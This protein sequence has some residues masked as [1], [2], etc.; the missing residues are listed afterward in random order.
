MSTT[1]KSPRKVALVALA[2]AE[3]TLRPYSH[4]FSPRTFTQPQLFACLAIKTFFKTDYRGITA[5]LADMPD[6]CKAIGLVKVPHFTTLQ[7]AARRLMASAV[8]KKI[9]EGTIRQ[10]LG[11]QPRIELAAVDSTGMESHHISQYFVRR[12]ASETSPWQSMH[13]T[14][15]PKLAVV[16]D[17]KSHIILSTLRK[18]GPT[19]DINQLRQTLRPAVGR[20]KIE[21]LLA[22]AGYDSEPNHKF[23]REELGI[24]TIIPARHGRPGKHPPK[25]KYRRLMREEFDSERYGQRW[26]VETVF[27]MIK[28]NL[29]SALH[30][31]SYWSQCRELMLLAIT[32]NIMIVMPVELFYRAVLTPLFGSDRRGYHITALTGLTTKHPISDLSPAGGG[33]SVGPW[34]TVRIDRGVCGRWR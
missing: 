31:R 4:R 20:A 5:I 28:R 22:D 15:Y 33:R 17:C 16:C 13:Y 34:S 3:Q 29:G 27:S 30:G 25:G 32:H 2:V 24:T 21:T 10:A 9:L 8:S 1:S 23:A 18:R 7:K 19:P 26:Q 14:K 11:E 6:L 12:R